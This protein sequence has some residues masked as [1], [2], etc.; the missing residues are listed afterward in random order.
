M[1]KTHEE[2]EEEDS[3]VGT[4]RIVFGTM[5]Y[6]LTVWGGGKK[7]QKHCSSRRSMWFIF[8]HTHIPFNIL[9]LVKINRLETVSYI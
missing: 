4:G 5:C 7:R 6:T 3:S 9:E 8:T 1:T 2:E